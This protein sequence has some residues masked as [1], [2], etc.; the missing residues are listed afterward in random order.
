MQMSETFANDI[1]E[2]FQVS[3]NAHRISKW[4]ELRE[5]INQ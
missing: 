5:V 2:I 4:N 3:I 1:V